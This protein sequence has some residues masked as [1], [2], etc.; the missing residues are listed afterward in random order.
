MEIRNNPEVIEAR[1]GR[2]RL[3]EECAAHIERRTQLSFELLAKVGDWNRVN[4]EHTITLDEIHE[5][6]QKLARLLA[7]ARTFTL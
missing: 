1:F 4:A 2:A 5:Y 3:I 6:C 7:H